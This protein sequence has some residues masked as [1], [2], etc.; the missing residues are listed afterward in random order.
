MLR[1]QDLIVVAAA[2]LQRLALDPVL[3]KTQARIKLSR[4]F[5]FADYTQLQHFHMLARKANHRFRQSPSHAP[6]PG[7]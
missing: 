6:I 5:I 1:H 7:I 4:C 3:H 2:L